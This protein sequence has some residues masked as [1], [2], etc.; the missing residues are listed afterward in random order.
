MKSPT[1]RTLELLR[2][3]GWTAYPV[4]YFDARFNARHDLLGIMDVLALR[5]GAT[6]G[7]Q[8]T[9]ASNVSARVRKIMSSD[10]RRQWLDAGNL[11][12]VWG[13]KKV[14]RFWEARRVVIVHGEKP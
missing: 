8:A 11:L 13:W 12:E 6:L 5:P 4:E 2:K 10:T 9:T 7:V 14:G 1:A 3:E